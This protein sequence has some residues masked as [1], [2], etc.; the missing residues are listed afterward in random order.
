LDVSFK[1][2]KW[3]EA[4]RN[5]CITEALAREVKAYNVRAYL[6]EPGLFVTRTARAISVCS[7]S[8][9]PQVVCFSYVFPE[10]LK[11]ETPPPLFDKSIVEIAA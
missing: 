11:Q 4:V 5:R 9:Y 1:V 3:L 2:Y 6:V 8:I 10:S 7:D